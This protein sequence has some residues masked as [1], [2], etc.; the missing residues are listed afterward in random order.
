MASSTHSVSRSP[1]AV[2]APSS[3]RLTGQG[4]DPGGS[5]S[6]RPSPCTNRR[7]PRPH[8]ARDGGGGVRALGHGQ[9]LQRPDLHHQVKGAAPA[10]GQ[11]EE[12]RDLVADGRIGKAFPAVLDR[13]RNQVEGRDAVAAPADLFG[14][15]A[16][17]ARDDQRGAFRRRRPGLA[18]AAGRAGPVL[19]LRRPLLALAAGRAVPV[20]A[21]RRAVLVLAVQPRHQRRLRGQRGPRDRAQIGPGPCVDLVEASLAGTARARICHGFLR[22]RPRSPYERARK[23]RNG[24]NG[25]ILV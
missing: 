10:G 2:K 1:A 22:T 18:L 9:R 4:R 8:R 5:P 24:V 3:R 17:P 11:P 15:V 12:V 19:A 7:P 13:R 20:L 6:S 23:R 16:Q 25:T 21:V 14:V